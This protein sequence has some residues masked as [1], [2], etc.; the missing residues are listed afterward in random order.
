MN[1]GDL[2]FI[3]PDPEIVSPSAPSAVIAAGPV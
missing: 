1:S 3:D 2:P